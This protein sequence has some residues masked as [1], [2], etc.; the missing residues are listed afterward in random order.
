[1]AESKWLGK[2][3][4]KAERLGKLHGKAQRLAKI[5]TTCG[6]GEAERQTLQ[7]K[8]TQLPRAPYFFLAGELEEKWCWSGL[9]SLA[10]GTERNTT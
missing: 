6:H 10:P 1:M 9:A 3:R 4:G 7:K 5:S 2:L 8:C